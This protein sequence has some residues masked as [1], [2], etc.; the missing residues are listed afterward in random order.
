MDGY[1][2]IGVGMEMDCCLSGNTFT[3]YAYV[4]YAVESNITSCFRPGLMDCIHDDSIDCQNGIYGDVD[5]AL[6]DSESNIF[7]DDT[8]DIDIILNGKKS[9]IALDNIN[10]NVLNLN[11]VDQRI[12]ILSEQVNVMLIDSYITNGYDISYYSESCD[13]LKNNRLSSN[14]Y[15]Y[16]H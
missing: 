8:Y 10:I 15:H 9:N 4:L 3:D 16:F 1:I 11:I 5:A 6:F 13:L 7:V 14:T 12:V 2:I